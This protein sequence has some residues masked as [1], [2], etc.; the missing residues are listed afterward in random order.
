M[1]RDPHSDLD[2]QK[3]LTGTERPLPT[4]IRASMRKQ[5]EELNGIEAELRSLS[6]TDATYHELRRKRDEV[7]TGLRKTESVYR[8][9]ERAEKRL[10]GDR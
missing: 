1:D 5:R 8:D 9:V 6:T 4:M 2:E 10:R 7:R 3:D